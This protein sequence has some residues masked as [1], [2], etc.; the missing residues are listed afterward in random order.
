MQELLQQLASQFIKNLGTEGQGL[1]IAQVIS[2]LSSL[3]PTNGG[4]LDIAALVSQFSS[5]GLADLAS[6]WLSDGENSGISVGQIL[7]VLGE[8]RVSEFACNLGLDTETAASGLAES[9]PG[10]I[11]ANSSAGSLMG[12]AGGMLG[13]LFK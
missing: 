12:A 13:K 6:S 3:L 1:D 2:Q 11:D 10:I 4:Q 7:S 9:L 8:G 5:S